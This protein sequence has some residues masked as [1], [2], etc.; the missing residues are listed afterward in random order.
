M[1]RTLREGVRRED[2]G[3]IQQEMLDKFTVLSSYRD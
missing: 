1:A 2:V 3:E